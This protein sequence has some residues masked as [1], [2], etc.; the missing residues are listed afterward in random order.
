MLLADGT[1]DA[2]RAR[3]DWEGTDPAEEDAIDVEFQLYRAQ[4]LLERCQIVGPMRRDEPLSHEH[5]TRE[6]GDR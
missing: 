2:A 1:K 6:D 4:L 3:L 5:D